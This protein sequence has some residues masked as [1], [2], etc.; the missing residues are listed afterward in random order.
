MS[1]RIGIDLGTS[2]SAAAMVYDDG[3]GIIPR[4]GSK[5]DRVFLPSAVYFRWEAGPDDCLVGEEAV[6]GE[7]E[8]VVTS[9]KRL[10]GRTYEQALAEEAE[11]YF[12]P[13]VSLVRAS[14]NDLRVR[15]G[16]EDEAQR[17]FWPH[18][19][20]ELIL[21]EIRHRAEERLGEEIEGAVITVP[22]YFEGPHRAATIEAARLAGIK[23]LAPLIDEPTAAA[24]AFARN[25]SF[26]PGE[27]V[28][29]VDWG[30]GT[31]DVVVMETGNGQW[32]QL[33]VRGDLNLGG[34]DIDDHIA[35]Y[36]LAR[37]NL[38]TLLSLGYREH[39]AVREEV[40]NAK[41]L[42]SRVDQATLQFRLRDTARDRTV[43]SQ[44]RLS[45]GDFEAEIAPFVD[46]M[47]RVVETC[48]D[49]PN[50][51]KSNIRKVLLVGG[52]TLIPLVRK[53]LHEVLPEAR[54]HHDVD[55]LLA[56]ALGAAI[57][58][59]MR[60]GD[61]L[62]SHPYGYVARFADGDN[63]IIPPDQDIPTPKDLP[64]TVFPN[65]T[66][67]YKGQ[68]LFRLRLRSF[69]SD[70]GERAAPG[71]EFRVFGR[72]WPPQDA[73]TPLVCQFWL[74][75]DKTL[76]VSVR[77]L[78]STGEATQTEAS[79]TEIGPNAQRTALEDWCLDAEAL[80]EANSNNRS[81]LFD[82]LAHA[83]DRAKAALDR[84]LSDSD[85]STMT[86]LG[87]LLQQL[88]RRSA[89]LQD[90]DEGEEGERRRILGWVSYYENSLLNSYW[91]LLDPDE[92]T[93]LVEGIRRIRIMENANATVREMQQ[94][95]ADL[96]STADGVRAGELLAGARA[97]SIVGVPGRIAT[98][99]RALCGAGAV[100]FRKGDRAAYR[101]TAE[102]IRA[103]VSESDTEWL[104]WSST[105]SV[106]YVTPDLG[107]GDPDD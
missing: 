43:I 22:A 65:P 38:P 1:A 19:I 18:Q 10:M 29:V 5:A 101:K 84:E 32:N 42:L 94:A 4:G 56:V 66:T 64:Y 11:Q 89:D 54:L 57:Y 33:L 13:P 14:T 17:D 71:R 39:L 16:S 63:D 85:N 7:G 6:Q 40:R 75:E 61:M 20:S 26:E 46:T 28:L 79:M 91:N 59:Q 49:H 100:L 74:D 12:R 70:G 105:R 36:L 107:Q 58:A 31:L 81:P 82:E 52:S 92:R 45:R 73:K 3:P 98:E 25:V 72:G 95:L 21:R 62:N 67:T 99:L 30:G 83:C 76:K 77:P 78:G 55:P 103:K 47:V 60:R 9:I 53:R 86:R 23:V 96:R 34:D 87:E 68:T 80:L 88:K 41:H 69:T 37:R 51:A 48:L 106:I 2:N 93:R 8:R 35:N 90:P 50:V 104:K 27:P 97:A 44:D 24:L 15:V 102:M